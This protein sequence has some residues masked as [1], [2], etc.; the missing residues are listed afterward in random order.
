MASV[1]KTIVENIGLNTEEAK[2]YEAILLNGTLTPGEI[3]VYTE[4]PIDKVESL[5]EKLEKQQIVRK[6]PGIVARYST[7]PPFEKLAETLEKFRKE[8]ENIRTTVEQK[9]N[10]T[11]TE[12]EN[13]VATWKSDVK[14]IIGKEL[15][16]INKENTSIAK[17]IEKI[18]LQA[19]KT[20]EK[21][22]E[23]RVKEISK[24]ITRQIELYNNR[25]QE[26]E[27]NLHSI[28]DAQIEK[29]RKMKD[30]KEKELSK[31]ID[32][33]FNHHVENAESLGENVQNALSESLGT[34]LENLDQL[35]IKNIE[36]LEKS[37]AKLDELA[38][39]VKNEVFSVLHDYQNGFTTDVDE[40][41]VSVSSNFQNQVKVREADLELLRDGIEKK[42][43]E[44]SIE[45]AKILANF[46]Y[47]ASK[48]LNKLFKNHKEEVGTLSE[49][50]NERIK[51][52]Y[53]QASSIIEEI[54]ASINDYLDAHIKSISKEYKAFQKEFMKTIDVGTKNLVNASTNLIKY[55]INNIDQQ[56]TINTE[57][58]E[59]LKNKISESIKED[60]QEINSTLINIQN[61]IKENL[62]S[63]VKTYSSKL[64]NMQNTLLTSL[65]HSKSSLLSLV[66]TVITDALQNID[67][68]LR[69]FEKT[70]KEIQKKFSE[71]LPSNV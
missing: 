65:D 13:S 21:E 64:K 6:M 67:S 25:I 18:S 34:L 37:L 56:L 17:S 55:C 39:E 43:L 57:T 47:L 49:K 10:E 31:T 50:L 70:I 51:T 54:K 62:Q 28:L 2:I 68:K 42:I 41:L 32:S 45:N 24:V 14:K 1:N 61:E 38:N 4:F 9:F 33:N 36:L 26:Y 53:N 71:N 63:G 40:F 3:S 19:S 27:N 16:N 29:S 60:I 7:A 11:L 59:G 23:K 5:L 20:L 35:K 30:I 48:T 22:L 8:T 12:L 15:A 46:H 66:Q 44:N 52:G 58:A 69:D